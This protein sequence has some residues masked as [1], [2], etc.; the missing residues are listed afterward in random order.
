[1]K[2]EDIEDLKQLIEFLKEYQVSEFDLDRG[3]LKIRLKFGQPEG[4]VG[5]ADLARLLGAARPA[6]QTGEVPAQAANPAAPTPEAAAADA[7]LHVVK[8]PMVGT[9]YGSPSPGAG[10][11]VSPGDLVTKGQVIGIVEAMKLMNEIESDAAGEFVKYLVS[12]GQ[13]VEYGQPLFSL[14]IS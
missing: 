14:R 3:D 4:A 2:Q 9:F 10:P 5:L 6:A 1:M 11:F 8:S 7:G 13:P 12:N